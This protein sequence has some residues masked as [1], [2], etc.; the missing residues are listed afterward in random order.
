MHIPYLN[1][2]N[3]LNYFT[4]SSNP[5]YD[6]LCNNE[7]IRMRGGSTRELEKMKGVEYMLLQAQEPILYVIR[8]QHRHSPSMVVPLANYYII[9]G[10]IYQAP[11][12]KSILESKLLTAMH[13]LQSAFEECFNYARFHPSVDYSWSFD[14]D[15][16]VGQSTG[17]KDGT[18]FS[19]QSDLKKDIVQR[20]EMI[21]D[22]SD[23]MRS[24]YRQSVDLLIRDLYYKFPPS[25]QKVLAIQSNQ[26][27]TNEF[28]QQNGTTVKC[29]DKKEQNGITI[30]T[31][32]DDEF[33]RNINSKSSV[34]NKTTN[35]KKPRLL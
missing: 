25:E 21:T 20:K 26:Q 11:D 7:N 15:S 23:S 24:K 17:S 28:N 32:N 8:K 12:L 5:F 34:T 16:S 31:E 6:K 29:N 13:S 1:Q 4:D 22:A 18:E 2:H 10:V 35:S 19:S 14:Q 3:V 9:A 27:T 30:K 33:E